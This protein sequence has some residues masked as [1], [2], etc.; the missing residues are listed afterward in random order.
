MV[1]VSSGTPWVDAIGLSFSFLGLGIYFLTT[2]A[3]SPNPLLTIAFLVI[4][5]VLLADGLWDGKSNSWKLARN[6]R[7]RRG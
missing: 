4:G 2:P 7:W 6:W 1:W 5:I 3:A